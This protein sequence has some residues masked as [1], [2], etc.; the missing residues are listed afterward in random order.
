MLAKIPDRFGTIIVV[1]ILG[2][3]VLLS[4]LGAILGPSRNTNCGGPTSY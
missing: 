1:N 3:L 2:N 4:G